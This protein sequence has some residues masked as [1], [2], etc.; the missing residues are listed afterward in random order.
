MSAFYDELLDTM[1]ALAH[2]AGQNDWRGAAAFAAAIE[3][4]V[5]EGGPAPLPEDAKALRDAQTLLAEVQERAVPAHADMQKLM[6]VMQR[7]AAA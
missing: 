5:A 2:C 4:R 7:T 6:A 3:A 1:R